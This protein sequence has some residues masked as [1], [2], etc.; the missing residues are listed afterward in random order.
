MQRAQGCVPESVTG[1]HS[2]LTAVLPQPPQ[3]LPGPPS[4]SHPYSP[5]SSLRC[6]GCLRVCCPQ[7]L[8]PAAPLPA[9]IRRVA[10]SSPLLVLCTS[11]QPQACPR[12][13]ARSLLPSVALCTADCLPPASSSAL[14]PPAMQVAPRQALA[15]L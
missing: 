7:P 6:R 3:H 4:H 13:S 12:S 15:A 10:P 9:D 14:L 8:S 2:H 1:W 11:D 5:P